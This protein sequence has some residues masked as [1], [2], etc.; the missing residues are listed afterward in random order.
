MTQNLVVVE[1]ELLNQ[2]MA[3]DVFIKIAD[4]HFSKEEITKDIEEAFDEMRSFEKRF[5]R[6]IEHNELES[7]NNSSGD[8]TLSNELF[9]VLFL[10]LAY[11]KKTNGIFNISLLNTLKD[12]GYQ[13]SKNQGFVDPNFNSD[14]V[15]NKYLSNLEDLK[16]LDSSQKVVYKPKDLQIDLGGIGKGFIVQKVS[17]N[18]KQKYANFV[19]D[20]GGDMFVS[21]TNIEEKYE[22]WAIGV[23]H[24]KKAEEN[25]EILTV[26]DKGIATS[27]VNKRFWQYK[28]ELKNHLIDP[29]VNK[30]V[31]NSLISVTVV[32]NSA[33]EADIYA[34]ALLIMGLDIAANFSRMNNIAAL[35]VDKALKVYN[36]AQM[37]KY[38]FNES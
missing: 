38:V 32:A 13:V 23:E 30:S 12:E 34:K 21:G 7:F 26:S 6:F 11:Y 2:I 5:S 16:I 24:P 37:E 9:D 28:G 31:E 36:T 25:L 27:G 33:V 14:K 19:V 3:T 15:K 18:L 35:F 4:W 22:F 8:L 29:K 10:A 1:K 20:A 17:D